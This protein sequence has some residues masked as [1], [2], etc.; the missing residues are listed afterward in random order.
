MIIEKKLKHFVLLSG[1][2]I[3]CRT[4]EFE[5]TFSPLYP[6]GNIKELEPIVGTHFETP[7]VKAHNLGLWVPRWLH[8]L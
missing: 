4:N 1:G 6:N 7:I 3:R 8:I 5:T 2:S